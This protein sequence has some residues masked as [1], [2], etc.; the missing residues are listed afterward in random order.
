MPQSNHE[1]KRAEAGEQVPARPHES[2]SAANETIDGLTPPQRLS[3]TPPK[4]RR[5]GPARAMSRRR[6]SLTGL[7]KRQKS[8]K[9]NGK[10]ATRSNRRNTNRSSP[11]GTWA[12]GANGSRDRH[13]AGCSSSWRGLVCVFPYLTDRGAILGSA[14]QIVTLAPTVTVM[15]T[16]ALLVARRPQR[17]IARLARLQFVP[18]AVLP[19]S[20]F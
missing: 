17:H 11:S 20:L 4:I 16:T 14:E 6:R 12:I 9:G 13:G 3:G 7:A 2:G 15:L 1:P 8:E 19:S 10:K 5:P 18:V